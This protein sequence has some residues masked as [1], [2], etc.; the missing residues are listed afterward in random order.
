MKYTNSLFAFLVIGAM[1]LSFGCTVQDGGSKNASQTGSTEQSNTILYSSESLGQ[2]SKGGTFVEA[3]TFRG[4][5]ECY[6][7]IRLGELTKSTISKHFATELKSGKLTYEHLNVQS[8]ENRGIAVE[9]QVTAISLQLGTTINGV[10][11]RENLQQVW[12]YLEDE[13]GFEN[14]L[15]PLLQKRLR[16]ELN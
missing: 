9:Y 3:F 15:V 1:L 14:Y 12:Y 4:N 10:K 2:E 8:A 5:T 13:Q 7:C 16:G 11:T 6:S